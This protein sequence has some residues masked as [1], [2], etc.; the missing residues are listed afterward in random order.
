MS[1]STA[2]EQL[3]QQEQQEQLEQQEQEQGQQEQASEERGPVRIPV[4]V[5]GPE[6]QSHHRPRHHRRH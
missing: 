2:T 3:E 6:W 5:R 4:L 1:N